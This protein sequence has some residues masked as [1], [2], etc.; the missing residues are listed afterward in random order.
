M[1]GAE[2]WNIAC[3]ISK[4]RMSQSS[5]IAAIARGGLLSPEG[6]QEAKNTCLLAGIRL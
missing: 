4:Q 5:G 6:T 3:H 2:K 1:L